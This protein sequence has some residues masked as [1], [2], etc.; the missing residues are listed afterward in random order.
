MVFGKK[1]SYFFAFCLGVKKNYNYYMK[2]IK[3]LK[4]KKLYV[5]VFEYIHLDKIK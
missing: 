5:F 2:K 1:I 3:Y 4:L